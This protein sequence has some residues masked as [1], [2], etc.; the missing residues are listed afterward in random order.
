MVTQTIPPLSVIHPGEQILVSSDPV[1][2][3][4]WH[5]LDPERRKQLAQWVGQ[6]I[7][8]KRNQAVTQEENQDERC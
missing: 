1:G 8:R 4:L 6:M 5:Q 2:E 7:Q 3:T